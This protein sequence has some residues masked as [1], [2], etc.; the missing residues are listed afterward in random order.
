MSQGIP[1]VH[2]PTD[3]GHPLLLHVQPGHV[4]E[5]PNVFQW[6]GSGKPQQQEQEAGMVTM[7]IPSFSQEAKSCQA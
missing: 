1:D 3:H 5:L 4:Q 6:W 2:G 7:A